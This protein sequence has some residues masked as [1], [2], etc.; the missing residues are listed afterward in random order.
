MDVLDRL[1]DR[2]DRLAAL[3]EERLGVRGNGLEA[4]LNRAGRR[5]PRWV[6]REAGRLVEARRMAAHP[7]LMRRTDP[8][9]LDRAFGR[10]ESWLRGIDPAERRKDRILGPLAVNAFNLLVVAGLFI[11]YL[12]WAGH[13]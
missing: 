12:V 13:V 9:A 6:R 7:K 1:D 8:D 3:I 4:K 5:L 11:A 2:A 10:C